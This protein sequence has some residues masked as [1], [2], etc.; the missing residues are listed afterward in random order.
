MSTFRLELSDSEDEKEV[1]SS[2]RSSCGVP[3]DNAITFID[4]ECHIPRGV[5]HLP[6]VILALYSLDVD[7]LIPIDNTYR[8]PDDVKLYARYKFERE[9]R[10]EGRFSN[11]ILLD[12]WVKS[13]EVLGYHLSILPELNPTERLFADHIMSEPV[14]VGPF[15]GDDVLEELMRH[16]SNVKK[17]GTSRKA[18]QKVPISPVSNAAADPTKGRVRGKKKHVLVENT[19]DTSDISLGFPFWVLQGVVFFKKCIKTLKDQFVSAPDQFSFHHLD[20]QGAREELKAMAKDYLAGQAAEWNTSKYIQDYET[21]L[22]MENPQKEEE[23]EKNEDTLSASVGG[24]PVIET[25]DIAED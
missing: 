8:I 17:G 6:H 9:F 21:L 10:V 20:A 24:M 18:P 12:K 1:Y 2:S 15:F 25:P 16:K 5:V 4:N 7:D 14:T 19:Q 13:L 22:A 3:V 23:D 11:S